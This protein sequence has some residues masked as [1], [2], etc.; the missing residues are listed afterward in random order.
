MLCS[1]FKNSIEDNYICQMVREH[2][3]RR[4]DL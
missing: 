4:K 2:Q 1:A 3:R